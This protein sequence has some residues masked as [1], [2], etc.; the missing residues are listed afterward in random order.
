MTA[1]GI[2]LD[3]NAMS[4]DQLNNNLAKGDWDMLMDGWS[5]GPDPTYLLSI[6]TCGTLPED[7]GTNGN[8]DAFFCNKKYDK[9][10]KQAADAV[11]RQAARGDDR[12]DAGDPLRRQRRP[13]PVLQER[14]RTR[15]APTRWSTTCRAPSDSTGFYPLQHGFTSWWKAKPAAGAPTASEQ[16]QRAE[17]ERL[18]VDRSRRRGRAS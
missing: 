18:Q 14:A 10:Y 5:T 6:Q 15:C 16:A 1:I 9:L 3:V 8:T 12:R 17:L 7:D 4:F 2:K 13:D 11:R